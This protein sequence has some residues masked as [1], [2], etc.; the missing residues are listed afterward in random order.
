VQ[1]RWREFGVRMALG[2]SPRNLLGIVS[3]S[4]ARMMVLGTIIGLAAAAALARALSAFLFGGQPLDATT[5]ASMTI[6]MGVTAV[7]ASSVPALRAARVDP[8][9]VSRGK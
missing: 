2:A 4:A 9:V 7:L 3:G 6:V 1:Q 5:F 8:A